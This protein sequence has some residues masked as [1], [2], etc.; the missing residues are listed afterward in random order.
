MHGSSYQIAAKFRDM[1]ERSAARRGVLFDVGDV[2]SYDVN[3]SFRPLFE[4]S[5]FRSYTGLDI[6]DG[7]GVDEVVEPYDFGRDRFDVVIS[8]STMEHTQ[9]VLRWAS[10]VVAAVKPGGLVC[11]IAPHTWQEHRHPFDC[12]RIFPDGMRYAFRERALELGEGEP[13]RIIEC[14][15]NNADTWLYARKTRDPR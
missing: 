2:G 6:A 4:R 1:C 8:G 15:R 5:P 3:G 7:P 12:W 9:D 10:A 14:S 11:I 13:L